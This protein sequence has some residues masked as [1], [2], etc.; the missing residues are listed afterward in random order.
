MS[1]CLSLYLADILNSIQKIQK[2]TA[3]LTYEDL[4]EN[5]KTLDAVVHNLLIIGE[6]TKQIPNI[7][8]RTFPCFNFF[9]LRFLG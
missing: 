4:C 5:D 2:Y 9:T 7:V 8:N 1:R 6:A 3:N